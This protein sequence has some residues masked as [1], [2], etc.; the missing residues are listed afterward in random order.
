MPTRLSRASQTCV[1][2]LRRL[3]SLRRQLGNDVIARLAVAVI[4][5]RLDYCND[6]LAGVD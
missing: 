3:R 1:S 5:S 2:Q 6:V 4:L